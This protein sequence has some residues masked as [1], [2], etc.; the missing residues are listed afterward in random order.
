MTKIPL[1]PDDVL[2]PGDVIELNYDL[3]G[4]SWL[5]LQAVESTMIESRLKAKYEHFEIQSYEWTNDNSHLAITVKDKDDVTVALICATIMTVAI[6]YW[7]TQG[8]TYKIV[9]EIAPAM[10]LFALAA[11]LYFAVRLMGKG[12]LAQ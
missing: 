8:T 4:P 12:G 2:K 1:Q 7:F 3:I 11:V 5:W 6:V 9:H 10:T